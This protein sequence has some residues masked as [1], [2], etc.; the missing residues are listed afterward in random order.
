MMKQYQSAAK[1]VSLNN[2]NMKK[3]F[4]VAGL[5]VLAIGLFVGHRALIRRER[6][7]LYNPAADAKAEIADAVKQAS[8]EHKH[9][10]LQIGGNWCKW[11]LRFNDFV[12]DDPV[13]DKY[14]HDNYILVHVNYSN[15][16]TNKEVLAGLG[17]PQRLG[18]PAFVILDGKGN[19]LHSQNS[20][21]LGDVNG[22]SEEKVLEFFKDWSPAAPDAKNYGNLK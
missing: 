5:V 20:G 6:A 21:G 19:R 10:M 18:F 4:I 1:A 11:C 3:L 13:L 8:K 2:F 12:T 17:Y 9:V 15:E 7:H 22:Y 14:L 16:N